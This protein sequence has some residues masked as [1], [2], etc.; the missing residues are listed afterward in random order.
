MVASEINH[1]LEPFFLLINL[2]IKIKLTIM[3]VIKY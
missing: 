3:L 1:T 2:M